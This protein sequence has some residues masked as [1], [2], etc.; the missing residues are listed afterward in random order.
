MISTK[1]FVAAKL[2]I[3]GSIP[4]TVNEM[5]ISANGV[6]RKVAEARSAPKRMELAIA[7]RKPLVQVHRNRPPSRPLT[8]PIIKPG[9]NRTRISEPP[10][11]CAHAT[12]GEKAKTV[13]R[14]LQP[15]RVPK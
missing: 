5:R 9:T 11:F 8:T 12:A 13:A 15:S 1:P 10:I 6:V 2:T 4:N 7:T 3:T 14:I